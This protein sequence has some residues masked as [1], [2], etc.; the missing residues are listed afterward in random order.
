MPFLI[1]KCI[2]L[3]YQ[4]FYIQ[5]I[6]KTIH[7]SFQYIPTD[8]KHIIWSFDDNAYYKNVFNKCISQM[9]LGFEINRINKR[10]LFDVTIYDI[11][12]TYTQSKSQTTLPFCQYILRRIRTHGR[13]LCI[14]Q[15]HEHINLR[16]L[17]TSCSHRYRRY[18]K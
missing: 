12:S 3:I 14:P 15:Y 13:D 18:Q 9:I 16:S 8:I 4:Q 17:R 7:M 10:I 2:K 5:S 6:I 1:F 11:Y